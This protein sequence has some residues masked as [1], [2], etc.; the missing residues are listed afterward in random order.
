MIHLF[1]I[2]FHLLLFQAE[3]SIKVEKYY[4]EMGV[5]PINEAK[6]FKLGLL[7][8]V[9]IMFT[10]DDSS[11]ERNLFVNLGSRSVTRY[12]FPRRNSE[13]SSVAFLAICSIQSPE[14]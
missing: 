6:E 2:L 1:I 12:F 4:I 7:G 14:N 5:V 11:I 13:N 10:P 3:A 9:R 8:G